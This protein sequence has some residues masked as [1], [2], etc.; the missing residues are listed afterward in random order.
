M[1]DMK[2]R[3]PRFFEPLLWSYHFSKI[4]PEKDKKVIIVN[5][6]NYGDLAHWHW[7]VSFYG[8]ETV[9]KVLTGI[10][11][12]ELRPSVRRLV[13]LLFSIENFNHAP[14]GTFS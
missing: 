10:V 14:R 9:R 4:D 7:L 5:A 6:M 3:L 2:R 13:S 12:T 1:E 8:K 11:T